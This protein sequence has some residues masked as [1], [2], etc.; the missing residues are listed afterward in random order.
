MKYLKTFESLQPIDVDADIE[1]FWKKFGDLIKKR[2]EELE[3]R[4][5]KRTRY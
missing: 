5:K 1:E 3:E 4:W 2:D